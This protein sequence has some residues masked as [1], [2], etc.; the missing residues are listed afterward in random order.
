MVVKTKRLYILRHGNAEPFGYD[1]DAQRALTEQGY[2]EVRSTAEQFAARDEGFDAIFV[3][4]YLRAQQTA[5]E[6]IKVLGTQTSPQTLDSIT[7]SGKELDVAL[8]L[9]D[10][11]YD[12]VL[13]VTHQPFAYQLVDMLADELLPAAFQMQTATIAALEGELFATACCQFRWAIS[14]KH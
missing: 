2:D 9:H 5:S 11:P 1:Q 3:S 8:W 10:L 6:F 12:S 14:P 7:P 13:L 4:P